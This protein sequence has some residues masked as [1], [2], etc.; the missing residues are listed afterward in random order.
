MA[1]IRLVILV[2]VA[3]TV[4]CGATSQDFLEECQ[5]DCEAYARCC[6]T[7][8]VLCGGATGCSEPCQTTLDRVLAADCL[9][10]AVRSSRCGNAAAC[11][12]GQP[13]CYNESVEYFECMCDSGKDEGA[14]LILGLYL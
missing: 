7:D 8:P 2:L 1:N 4:S 5:Q 9:D 14:C 10:E 12:S 11:Y 6:A 3:A 13:D